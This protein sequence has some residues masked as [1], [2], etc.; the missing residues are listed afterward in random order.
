MSFR[1]ISMAK[2]VAYYSCICERCGYATEPI[3]R[4]HDWA[5]TVDVE[6][7]AALGRRGWQIDKDNKSWCAVCKP[8]VEAA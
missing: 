7:K 6:V 3:M 1:I 8:K 4:G 2:D 5:S